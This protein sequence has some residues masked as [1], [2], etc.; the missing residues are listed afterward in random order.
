MT[1][2]PASFIKA[3]LILYFF[4]LYTSPLIYI[5][6]FFVLYT[7]P[8][9]HLSHSHPTSRPSHVYKISILS[10]TQK[11]YP[12]QQQKLQTQIPT[13]NTPKM[14]N[15]T[16]TTDP[17]SSDLPVLFYG[18]RFSCQIC[19]QPL[20]WNPYYKHWYCYYCRRPMN[21]SL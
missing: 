13:Q 6:T 16:N 18:A 17:S 9:S 15:H 2:N 1:S 10:Y 8:L 7:S 20:Q 3:I 21:P 11:S 14:C 4:M 5:S 19:Y 12:S